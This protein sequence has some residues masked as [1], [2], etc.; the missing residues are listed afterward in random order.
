MADVP[1]AAA[2]AASDGTGSTVDTEGYD[3]LAA[4][5]EDDLIPYVIP[6]R[7]MT[8]HLLPI[9]KLPGKMLLDM[10]S[11]AAR[12]SQAEQF[13]I[14]SDFLDV[15]VAPRDRDQFERLMMNASPSLALDELNR[16]VEGMIE[17]I[18]GRP[19]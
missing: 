15:A 4:E 18:G 11:V 1:P 13:K 19:S 7:D 17:A 2:A 16:I 10:G 12:K 9:A 6:N 3:S 5:A 14:I 8:I